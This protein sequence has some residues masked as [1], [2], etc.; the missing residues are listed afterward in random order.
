VV[1]VGSGL[2][3]RGLTLH[4]AI[5]AKNTV[6]FSITR[7]VPSRTKGEILSLLSQGI[8][9]GYRSFEKRTITPLFPF[10]HGL[11]YTN[12]KY[13]DL[14]LSA[15]SANGHFNVSVTVQNTGTR[16]GREVVQIYLSDEK[17]SLPRPKKELKGFFKVALKAGESK[18]ES[19]DL[20]REALGFYDDRRME[21]LAEKGTW[22]VLVASSSADV[23]LSG[24]I[25][26]MDSFSWTG[27]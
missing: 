9:V 18:T 23:R 25:M 7:Y 17:S 26:L 4:S 14:K 27:L 16:D 24:Y 22:E 3:I 12:F 19:I 15:V 1:P 6:K 21:W 8:L 5:M 20:D 10:G 2:K 11:S 13:S